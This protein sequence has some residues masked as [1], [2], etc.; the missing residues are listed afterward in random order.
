MTFIEAAIAILR[1]AGRPLHVRELTERSIKM[2]L[3]SHL[4]RAPEA[5]MRLRLTQEAKKGE[6]SVVVQ[7]GQETFGLRQYPSREQI[8][9][10]EAKASQEAKAREVKTPPARVREATAAESPVE[11]ASAG[12]VDGED[13]AARKRRR[14]RGGR[15]R[16]RGADGVEGAT[17]AQ[18]GGVPVESGTPEEAIL[19]EQLAGE[20]DGATEAH[21]IDLDAMQ[22]VQAPRYPRVIDL[23]GD[24]V[25][26]AEYADEIAEGSAVAP[27]VEG[28]LVD[29]HTADEDRPMLA[30]IKDESARDRRRG[31]KE[32]GKPAREGKAERPKGK[33]DRRAAAPA[34]PAEPA[35]PPRARTPAAGR[36]RAAAPE[37]APPPPPPP[38][39]ASIPSA[40]SHVSAP[41]G[42]SP[43][44]IE[45]SISEVAIHLLRSLNDPRPVHARQLAAMA[46][47]RKLLT[48]DPEELWRAIRSALAGDARA[49]QAQGLRIRARHQ[50]AGL[51]TLTTARLE[52][53]VR[54]AED[55]LAT[56]WRDVGRA[57][58][59]ALRR[60]TARLPLGAL[61]QLA[62]MYLEHAGVSGVERV[63]RAGETWYLAG[64][65]RR[66]A[67][68]VK[69]L[70]AVRAGAAE[71]GRQAV[72]EL[73]AGVQVRKAD[74]GLLLAP[75]PLDRDGA[76]E[77][78]AAGP[79][80][81][82]YT[83]DAFAEELI[84]RGVG[85]VQTHLPVAYL[86]I[87]LLAELSEG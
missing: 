78:E 27:A 17:P 26:S 21:P 84:G 31:R 33:R 63:K 7:K 69:L 53:D 80:V 45:G 54:A 83:G 3:L 35:A 82:A 65:G 4:G 5:T 28:E 58:R 8:A 23:P 44:A 37:A 71:V 42:P 87:D 40:V 10:E 36:G 60:R 43:V 1:Q 73:R 29:E 66:G 86:D 85:V 72:G 74:E 76:R 34:A 81:T 39:Q 22:P 47:K 56:V 18:E 32:K 41:T 30:E 68:P 62:R 57:T 9:A 25:L 52:D 48:G 61:E 13:E 70:I 2:S 16:K 11:D 75:A 46:L 50:G 19:A 51:F 55:A 20:A 59:E 79:P 14:R 12:A 6:R 77:L 67:R 49:R 24:E 38:A 15:N 64:A